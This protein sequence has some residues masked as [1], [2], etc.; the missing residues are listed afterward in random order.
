MNGWMGARYAKATI[1][2]ALQAL[3]QPATDSALNKCTACDI[4]SE[5]GSC[6]PCVLVPLPSLAGLY[7]SNPST[8]PNCLPERIQL[9]GSP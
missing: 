6:A 1:C 2:H 4:L 3:V 7:P 5:L 8:D 9:H